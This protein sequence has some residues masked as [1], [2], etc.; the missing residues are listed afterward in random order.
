[1]CGLKRAWSVVLTASLAGLRRRQAGY[2]VWY[3]PLPVLAAGRVAELADALGSGSSALTCMRVQVPPRPPSASRR[4]FAA[5]TSS[6]TTRAPSLFPLLR[7]PAASRTDAVRAP[8]GSSC[9]ASS[10]SSSS[11][12]SPGGSAACQ[13]RPQGRGLSRLHVRRRAP[14]STTRGNSAKQ[15]NEIVGDPTKFE[16][17]K[18]LLA[19]LDALVAQQDE[20]AKRAARQEHPDSLDA[21]AEVFVTGMKVRA[22]G[23]ALF[24]EA[25]AGALDEKKSVK[26]GAIAALAGYLS[27]PDA[28]YQTLF[29]GPARR[30]MKEDDVAGVKVPTATRYLTADILTEEARH[31]DAP[32]PRH[33]GQA[34]R[35]PRRRP[36]RRDGHALE[37][38]PG[39][40]QEHPDPGVARPVVRHHG[41]EPGKRRRERRPR[42][43]RPRAAGRRQAHADRDHR[44]H[45]ARQEADGR[46]PGVRDPQHG[47]HQDEH[48]ARQG[49]ARCP[50]NAC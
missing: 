7:H 10:S 13:Q 2:S 36:R 32:G 18:A 37:H 28:Y 42:R 22:R 41:R 46:G 3:N 38:R 27:G 44:R 45:L 34:R 50:R 14:R 4:G 9:S 17:R 48:A 16:N 15:L 11:L 31:V 39:A 26:P 30:I 8:S 25:I 21:E 49:R 12:S 24:R 19:E 1:M 40:R 23:F 47:D 6:T 29:Y 35:H 43:G 20:I 5:W 33:L